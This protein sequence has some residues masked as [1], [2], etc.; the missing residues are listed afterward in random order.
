MIDGPVVAVAGAQKPERRR[1]DIYF[2]LESSFLSPFFSHSAAILIYDAVYVLGVR[3]IRKKSRQNVYLIRFFL[4]MRRGDAKKKYTV[5]S[6]VTVFVS[7]FI[8]EIASG[9]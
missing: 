9:Q 8:F 5:D 4:C 1:K 7:N 3:A 2:T 6:I